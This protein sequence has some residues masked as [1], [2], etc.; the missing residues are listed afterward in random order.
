MGSNILLDPSDFYCMD[1]NSSNSVHNIFFL[2][3]SGESKL[4]RFEKHKVV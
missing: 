1:R 3:S 4:Y 2:C